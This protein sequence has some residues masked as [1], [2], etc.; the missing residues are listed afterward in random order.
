[1]KIKSL[2]ILV[3]ISICSFVQAQLD[4]SIFDKKLT[5]MWRMI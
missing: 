1:M 5:S 4:Y 3:L 2:L